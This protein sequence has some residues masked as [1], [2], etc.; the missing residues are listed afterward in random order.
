MGVSTAFFGTFK[1]VIALVG[2]NR[3]GERYAAADKAF[4][5][6]E[7]ND[8][9]ILEALDGA[10]GNDAGADELRRQ[11][12]ELEEDNRKLAEAVNVLNAQ[13]QAIPAD[14]GKEMVRKFWSYPQVRLIVTLVLA[15][16]HFWLVPDMCRWIN[17]FH[18]GWGGY[19]QWV[20]VAGVLGG[21]WEWACAEF[22]RSGTGV[23]ALKA[24]VVA[25]G[26]SFALNCFEGDV[27]GGSFVIVVTGALTITNGA[28]WLAGQMAHSDGE[29]FA[30]LRSW[31]A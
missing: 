26:L 12:D 11:I 24:G 25:A 28:K 8:L 4:R 17:H 20:W 14:A 7:E 16:G 1:K 15:S 3:E 30:T 9:S 29:I 23:V 13:A 31:F 19:Y 5:M 22:S 18:R 10:F 21:F 6:C 27:F 2:S